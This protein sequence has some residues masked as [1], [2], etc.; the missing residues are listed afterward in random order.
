[1]TD[2]QARIYEAVRK[3]P[4]GKVTSY[5]GAAEL[6][7]FVPGYRYARAVGGALHVNPDPSKTPCHRVIRQDGFLPSGYAFGG[8]AVHKELL[9]AEG[10]KVSDDFKVS[11]T[12]Y[13][14]RKFF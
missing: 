1:M 12:V 5:A 8:M 13:Q 11:M 9:E 14:L 3:I 4:K 10:V 2:F 7:G 6:A